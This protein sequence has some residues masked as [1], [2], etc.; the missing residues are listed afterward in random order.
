M[1]LFSSSIFAD[2]ENVVQYRRLFAPEE[3]ILSLSSEPSI[4][5][6]RHLFES[7]IERLQQNSEKQNSNPL[8]LS[9]IVLQAKL[10][11]RQLTS[12]QGVFTLDSRT[13]KTGSIP[14]HPLSLAVHSLHWSDG[15]EA[16]FFCGQDGENRLLVPSETDS[17][18]YD[19]LQFQWSLQSRKDV[20]SGIV[21]DLA[22]P[23]CLSVE[24]QLDIPESQTLTASAGLV[25]PSAENTADRGFRTWHILLGHHSLTTLTVTADKT[26]PV[27][28]QKSA[29]KQTV[30]YYVEPQ[31]LKTD[32]TI[33]FGKNDPLPNE[34]FL[35]LETPLRPASVRYG[36]RP[37]TWTTSTVSPSKTGV[38]V[39]LSPFTDDEPQELL[40]VSYGSLGEGERWNLPRT[41]VVSPDVFWL[42]TR[43]GVRVYSPLRTRNIVCHQGAQV[44]Q[45]A[46]TVVNWAKWEL[47]VFQFFHDD[48]QIELEAV[49]TIPDVT[50]NSAVQTHW[51]DSEI[52]ADVYLDCHVSEGNL[53]LLEFPVAEHW[54]IDDVTS[55]PATSLIAEGQTFSWDVSDDTQTLRVQLNQ[56]LHSRRSVTLKLSCRFIHTLQ[57]QFLL[58]ELSPLKLSYRHGE[59]HY[60]ANQ[61]DSTA[62]SIKSNGDAALFSAPKSIMLGGHLLTLNGGVYLI[63]AH[64]QEINLEWEL[65]RS[66]YTASI[67]ENIYIDDNG[68]IPT[69]RIHCAPVDAPINRVFVLFTPFGEETAPRHWDWSLAD[70]SDLS[71]PFR[72]RKVLPEE[73][74]ALLPI[75]EQQNW[76]EHLSRG[77]IWEIN[78]DDAQITPF[79]VLASSS[80]PLAD[81]MP[82]PFALLP[83]ASAQKGEITIESPQRFDYRVESTRLASIPIVSPA[84]DHYQTI[85]SAFR[86]DSAEQL[87][88]SQLS[89]KKL[90]PDE[91]AYTAWVWSLRLDSQFEPEGIVRNRALFFVEN[92]GKDVLRIKLPRNID[93]TNVYAVWQDREQIPWEYNAD[94]ETIDVDLPVGRRFVSI[95]VE[96]TY[97]DTPFIQQ[98]KIRPHYPSVDVPILSGHW[99]SWFPPEYDVSLRYAT[100]D[101]AQ[102][103]AKPVV[104]SKALDYLLTG[105]FRSFLGLEWDNALYGRQR[106][107]EVE[108]AAQSFFDVIV[109]VLEGHPITTW[110]ELIGDDR[111]RVLSVVQSRL[112][113]T[114]SKRHVD[115][116]LLIDKQALEFLGITPDTPIKGISSI[117]VKTVRAELF[118]RMGLVLLISTRTRSDTV[119]YVFALSTSTM[120]SQ[121]RQFQ[122]VPAG[123]CVRFVPF[124]IFD[125]DSESLPEWIPA[126]NWRQETTLSPIPWLVSA[127]TLQ[128]T[129]LD[130]D[131]NAYELPMDVEQPLYIVHRQTFSALQWIAF[132]SL[133]LM[134]CRR[135]FSR[136]IVLC[137]LLIIFELIARSV[138]PC[139]IGIPSGAFL[140]VLVS[141]A[142]VLIRVHAVPSDMP[143]ERPFRDDSTESSPSFVQTH[144]VVRSLLLFGFLLVLSAPVASQTIFETTQPPVPTE[145]YLV[146]YPVDS[147]GQIVDDHV[148]LPVEFF[149]LLS[150]KV[151]TRNSNTSP[152]AN[153]IKAVYQGSLIRGNSGH[154]EC[155]NDFKV[156]YD[157]SLESSSATILLPNLPAASGGFFW[158]AQP[159]LPMRRD[160]ANSDSLSF[161]I[162]NAAPGRH[163]LEI[164]LSPKVNLRND[165]ETNHILF[166]IPK[167]PRSALQMNLP[168]DIQSFRVH[169]AL[170]EVRTAA[171][172]TP[173]ITAELGAVEQLSLTWVD[174]QNRSGIQGSEVEQLFWIQVKRS[175]IELKALFRFRING[176]KVQRL[177]IQTDP[178]WIRSGQF[179]CDEYPIAQRSEINPE[180]RS[181]D[182][183]VDLP[184]NVSQIDFPSPV[185]GNVTL[186]ADFV[187]RDFGTR[188]NVIGNLRLP[189]FSALQSR[190]TK[191]M[192]AVSA[193]PSLELDTPEEGRDGSFEA[194]WHGTSAASDPFTRLI[195]VTRE[196]VHSGYDLTQ[197]KPTWTVNVRTKK[198]VPKVTVT[199]SV[200]FDANESE[201]H[202]VGEFSS[203]SEV[204]RQRLSADH[205][206]QIERESIEVRDSQNLLIES[207]CQEISPQQ[208]LIFFRSPVTGKY[209]ITVRGYFETTEILD[210]SVQAPFLVPLLTFDEAQTNS[211]SLNCFRTPG[212]IASVSSSESSGW[213][214]LSTSQTVPIPESFSQSLPVGIWRK[215]VAVSPEMSLNDLVVR[216]ESNQDSLRFELRSNRPKVQS[217]TVLSLDTDSDDRWQ[218]K[219]DFTGNI[220]G[221]ELKSLSFHWDEL[222]GNNPSVEPKTVKWALELT[223][224]QRILTL[225]SDEPMRG[226]QQFT[227][228]VPLNTIGAS[229]SLP[230][231][232]PLARE[233]NP[234]ESEIVVDL[235]LK[236]GNEII[237]WELDQ[238]EP[239]GEQAGE[240]R[241][242]YQALDTAHFGA[243]IGQDESRLTALFYDISFLIKRDGTLLGM[244]TVDLKNQ[245]QDSFLL[246]MPPGYELIQISSAG[247]ILDRTQIRE[248]HEWRI[249][250]GISDYPQRFSILFRV[251]LPY[252]LKRWNRSQI[253]ATLQFPL[254]KGV[255][256]RETLWTVAFEGHVPTLHVKSA[257][258]E[259]EVIDLGEHIPLAGVNAMLSQVGVNLIR[260]N[261]L[262]HVLRSLP[263]SS[264]RED[265]QHW[266]SNWSDEW[267]AVSEKV[268]PQVDYLEKQNSTSPASLRNI[269]PNLLMRPI[270]FDGGKVVSPGTIRLFW[271]TMAAPTPES[272]KKNKEELVKEKFAEVSETQSQQ[273]GTLW[274]SQVYWQGRISEEIQ[275][276]F[277]TE[278]ETIRAIHFTSKPT[279]K[280]WMS[281]FSD[282]VLLGICFALLLPILVLLSVRWVH[283]MELWL[284]FPHFWGMTVGVLFWTFLPESFIGLIIIIGTFFS[285]FRPS[286]T[287]HRHM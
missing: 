65:T 157:V 250:L 276:L 211:T 81:S 131:W 66:N 236:Q 140:G 256:V 134:T 160:E 88:R 31:G 104:V 247:A 59:S 33:V 202:T 101:A 24:L 231:V 241:L 36:D 146:F 130:S 119:E 79:D 35:E 213:A 169:D 188:S 19:Q 182:S 233:V 214:K 200:L 47:Y 23:P 149:K 235:P 175:Q 212:V 128:W 220:T 170:G 210:K 166:A 285:L 74:R 270:D 114:D 251:Q 167:V 118:E 69:F 260:K 70:R 34:L 126:S 266:F 143:P 234:F 48:A 221:G 113:K 138:A 52:R 284:Q 125:T 244:A 176:G 177:T 230:V 204:F 28:R 73:M 100:P 180:L 253:A 27:V 21:F 273:Q 201:V 68:L 1:L 120:L 62:Y 147:E 58:K 61:I 9:K 63:N 137:A 238:L 151:E 192:L 243:K 223:G 8:S 14:I 49:D 208:Y 158:D 106:R 86:Y 194:R 186:R 42:E 269:K 43:C 271:Q 83:L 93:A 20:R 91:Q 179:Q 6:D 107:T 248:N 172:R 95:T 26:I 12:G 163:T 239:V 57:Q 283:L 77:E 265:V 85:R 53:F 190:I 242:L 246:Q 133:V 282:H 261:N 111:N 37:V 237:P 116:R 254:L 38:H 240:S 18:S 64:T 105:T 90:T 72:V 184:L 185:L 222:C 219:L 115:A 40:V 135:P 44:P 280:E 264:R 274:N 232:F 67:S 150:R 76:N 3:T 92:Q 267:N 75:P 225:S 272:L 183:L 144:L 39:D 155:A 78:F 173:S 165:D 224:G 198:A 171:Q 174:D 109:E 13:D 268:D 226:E 281:W 87:R 22:F 205:P 139:Y 102:A 32:T 103:S 55:Y 217:K 141:L 110:G 30:V 191:S 193:D 245:G 206:I 187:L 279:E 161:F 45:A 132:L 209:T 216:R 148:W 263:V 123:H 5:V 25:L 257:L 136:P 153:I 142:F 229:V 80:S 60:I 2:D 159:I 129:T 50:V 51:N 197:V 286:W 189:E 227:I 7:W 56:P 82:I 277:G 71:R 54:V 207:R 16:V 168:Q 259:N 195:G 181:F 218:M 196:R 203:D 84:R 117:D 98:R 89:L 41:R 164:A 4:S 252:P 97:K 15:R 287:R 258:D 96:Y 278:E 255:T 127:Q 124:E 199:Q 121:N 46:T 228:T 162:E 275:Y 145:P 29:I 178:R 122:S 17:H 154:I 94:Q 112:G 215:R 249:N 262:Y 99:I 156:T 10:E 11:G 108:S 152:H